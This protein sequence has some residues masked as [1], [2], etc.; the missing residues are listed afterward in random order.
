MDWVVRRLGIERLFA[1]CAGRQTDSATCWILNSLLNTEMGCVLFV[2]LSQVQSCCCKTEIKKKFR[3][4]KVTNTMVIKAELYRPIN[5]HLHL[6]Q[7][8]A[9]PS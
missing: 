9:T 6:S 2:T 4:V 8:A 3:K 5:P 7:E 1:S